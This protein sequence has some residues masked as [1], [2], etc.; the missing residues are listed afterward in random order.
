[1]H[2]ELSTE[3]HT[4]ATQARYTGVTAGG[5]STTGDTGEDESVLERTLRLRLGSRGANA[6]ETS[7][8]GSGA[9]I[10]ILMAAASMCT[11]RECTA[12]VRGASL[13]AAAGTGERPRVSLRD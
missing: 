3:P 11:S 9:L 7:R 2:P 8:C 6:G 10:A 5:I 1:M 13:R 4:L 12:L